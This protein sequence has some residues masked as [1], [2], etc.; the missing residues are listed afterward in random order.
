V[1]LE[2]S[3]NAFGPIVGLFEQDP[4][5][6]K[7]SLAPG[8]ALAPDGVTARFEVLTRMVEIH[9]LQ[10]LRRLAPYRPIGIKLRT[11]LVKR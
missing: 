2:G 3:K 9:N 8:C 5:A 1:V 4:Q 11:N 10:A 7:F 6:G